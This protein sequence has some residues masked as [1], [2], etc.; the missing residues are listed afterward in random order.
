MDE[1]HII[2]RRPILIN[3]TLYLPCPKD[4]WNGKETWL[5]LQT[6]ENE[7]EEIGIIADKGKHG[8]Y[9]AYFNPRQQKEEKNGRKNS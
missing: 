5:D 2:Y 1:K 3:G 6:Q 7:I 9:I 8:K 4:F